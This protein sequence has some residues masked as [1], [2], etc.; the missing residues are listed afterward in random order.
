MIQTD[1][2]ESLEALYYIAYNRYKQGKYVDAEAIFGVLTTIGR[3]DP[4]FWMGL[5]GAYQ[6][7]KKYRQAI[8]AF[9]AAFKLECKDPKASF[10]AAECY[11]AL[12]EKSDGLAALKSA[13]KALKNQNNPDEN[14]LA[15]INL[16]KEAW[17]ANHK[18]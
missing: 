7:Q 15:H 16:V 6:V 8:D 3:R 17:A 12:G 11:F 5:G 1:K 10:H 14:M 4:R 18:K 13:E 9:K 2:S